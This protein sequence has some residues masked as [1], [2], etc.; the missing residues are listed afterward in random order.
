MNSEPKTNLVKAIIQVMAA[1]KNIEKNMTVGDGRNSYKGVSDKD[2]KQK[3]GE[4]MEKAG[5][6]ILPIKIN[7]TVKIERWTD[8]YNKPKQS[9]FT[10]VLPDYLLMHTS[11]ECQEIQGYGHGIDPQDK[12]AGKATTYAL[13][14]TLLN[15]FMIP[16]GTIDDTDNNHSD[17]M[18]T[19]PVAQQAPPPQPAAQ[20]PWLNLVNKD[21]SVNQAVKERLENFFAQSGDVDT[22]KQ[23]VRISVK[24][25][26]VINQ[27]LG[28]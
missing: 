11:G 1:V 3:V 9:V 7:P 12:S 18:P 24:D 14:N 16:T 19:P 13:K 10:E 23:T 4:A 6:V 15:M 20:L 5:L 22:L 8:E 2:V 28:Y 21:G 27:M 17:T 25:Y 26:Q